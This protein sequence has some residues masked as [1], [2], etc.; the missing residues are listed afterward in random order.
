[1]NRKL[2]D[3]NFDL[4]LKDSEEFD[5]IKTYNDDVKSQQTEPQI[6]LDN[7]SLKN[8]R[9]SIPPSIGEDL[10]SSKHSMD[11]VTEQGIILRTGYKNKR[12]W[13]LLPIREGLDN[14]VDFLWRY[15]RGASDAY[16]K[17]DVKIIDDG[18]LLHIKIR[19][20]NY[21]DWSVFENLGVILYFEDRSGTKQSV[22]VISRGMLGDA[23]K[24]IA[25]LG[26]ALIHINDDGT[27]FVN[28][29]WQYPLIIR[30]NKKEYKIDLHVD[31]VKQ[32][33]TAIPREPEDL[34]HTDTEIELTLPII[35]EL[36]DSFNEQYIIDF[37]KKY[38]ILTTDI[39]FQFHIGSEKIEV[40]RRH[41]IAT[42]KEWSNIDTIQACRPDEFASRII[43]QVDKSKSVYS[44]LVKLREGSNLNNT[45]QTA[46][47]IQELI[48]DPHRDEKIGQLY[49]QLKAMFDGKAPDKLQLPYNNKTRKDMLVDRIAKIYDIDLKENASYKLVRGFCNDTGLQKVWGKSKHWGKMVD[50]YSYTHGNGLVQ[51]PFAF[52]IIAVPFRNPQLHET[53]VIGAINYSISPND[54]KFDGHYEIVTKGGFRHTVNNFSEIIQKYGF[55]QHSDITS[56][57]SCVI[58]A[59]LITP[60]RDPQG[61]DKSSL[62][63][64]VFSETIVTAVEKMAKDIRTFKAAGY[65]KP[66]NE[67]DYRNATRRKTDGK[68]S[69]K[70]L[71]TRFLQEKR[72]LPA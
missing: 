44:I 16:V 24:Q 71:L 51:Y 23:M 31:T 3:D 37:C 59:N 10:T 42:E 17:V 41:A 70:T 8:K 50:S 57:L 52:E 69:I 18:K 58:I 7:K 12:D 36:R 72:G 34:T 32:Q 46:I 29:Q 6:H 4:N 2:N 55:H 13:Y 47:S 21:D 33:I 14:N 26:Y 40:Q 65:K 38:A 64:Q 63:M 66:H 20:P 19:N 48:D 1:V 27:S 39:T 25:A 5:L 28:K 45:P 30:H 61:Y 53:E 22:H 15:Y 60:R 67:E 9:K 68:D 56:K 43:N 62:D 35:D 49:Q 11:Y 54:I